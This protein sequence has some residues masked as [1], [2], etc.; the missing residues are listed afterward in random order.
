MSLISSRSP[1]GAEP[2]GLLFGAIGLAVLFSSISNAHRTAVSKRFSDKR[3]RTLWESCQDRLGRFEEV[4][5]KMRREQI[6][7]LQ[8]M[9]KTIR[10]VSESLY[11]AL[12][13]A[14]LI[15]NEVAKT[16]KDVFSAPPTWQALS[17]DAQAKELYRIADKNIAE[18]RMQFAGLM[19]GVHRAEAQS[20]VFMTTLDSLRMKMLGYRLVGTTPEMSSMEFLDA[21]TEA[22]LQLNAIDQALE[23]LDFTQF[24]KMIAAVP[25]PPPEVR[26]MNQGS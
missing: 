18:Y 19:A 15:A 12:R 14:D 9:P 5:G 23:E 17:Q 11:G 4:L 24:P 8:E 21:M 2:A 1:F 10:R 16:E 7:D 25:P 6:A 13:R 3:F 26:H 20:A 22:K